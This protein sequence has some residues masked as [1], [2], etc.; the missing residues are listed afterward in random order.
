VNEHRVEGVACRSCG[1]TDL[2]LIISF[3]ETT[4]ADR[5]VPE[6]KLS[7]PEITAP[8]DLAFC[9]DCA[10]VQITVSVDPEILFC[11]DYPYFSS[12]SKHL[13]EHSRKNA[14]ELITARDLNANSLVVEL[15]SNDG[16]MLRNFV[17]RGIPVL[18]IDPAEPPVKKAIEAGIPTM[19]TFFT[20]DLAQKLRDEDRRADVV[21]ANN[22]LAHVPDLNGFVEGIAT[23]LNDDGVAVIE[24]PYLIDL[25]DHTEFDTIYHQHLCYFSVT[26]L[27]RL[28]R[29]H[30][31]FLNDV[32]RLEIHGGSLRLYVEP[33]E[34]AS[35]VVKGLLSDER[36][37]GVGDLDMYRD[38]AGRVAGVKDG[39]TRILAD[40]KADG[41]RIVGYAAAAKANTMLQYCGITKEHLDYIVDL[42]Q[43]KQGKYFGG[44]HLP[45]LPPDRLLE[46]QPDYVLL[47]AWNFA[48]EILKQQQAY[49]ERGGK[50]II[51]IPEPK[52][53]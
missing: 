8:L 46:D 26:A 16:Y 31:L 3:G 37:R 40:L 5:L 38:F 21:I 2:E 9:P 32:K 19:C 29:R 25:L 30:G 33:V 24:C 18:G 10:L 14:E 17:A 6:D 11:Q 52:I 39:L 47:L 51:P 49:R 42:N 34:N 48:D 15:A 1:G 13:L 36:R 4:L 45:I 20:V 27:D 22:V 7:E 43:F 44:S 41:K 28:F 23:L 35:E 50:F 53:V 12:V